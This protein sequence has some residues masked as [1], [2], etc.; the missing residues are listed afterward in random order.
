MDKDEYN[1]HK[2]EYNDMLDEAT[3]AKIK[4]AE[5][6]TDSGYNF[7]DAIAMMREKGQW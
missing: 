3:E 2:D 5:E 7:Y 6:L 1:N 4:K